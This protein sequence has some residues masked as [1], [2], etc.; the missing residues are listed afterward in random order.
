[1]IN[2]T[3]TLTPS[4]KKKV[5]VLIMIHMIKHHYT[6]LFCSLLVQ[7]GHVVPI[8]SAPLPAPPPFPATRK[9]SPYTLSCVPL[10]H[11]SQI[12]AAPVKTSKKS[13]PLTRSSVST[14]SSADLPTEGGLDRPPTEG[15]SSSDK[16]PIAPLSTLFLALGPPF[17]VINGSAAS[18]PVP[19]TALEAATEEAA[20]EVAA[21]GTARIGDVH[22][23]LCAVRRTRCF[24]RGVASGWGSSSVWVVRDKGVATAP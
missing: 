19:T 2:L 14:N 4:R 23:G 11:F 13:S 22:R 24:R 21:A 3:Y 6:P 8:P 5:K 9:Q 10:V 16:G 12:I 7:V 17:A 15:D 18:R 1:M 20:E